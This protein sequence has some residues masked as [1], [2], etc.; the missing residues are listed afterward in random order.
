MEGCVFVFAGDEKE[1]ETLAYWVVRERATRA[2]LSTVFLRKSTGEWIRRRLVA[3]LRE[4]GLEFADVIVNSDNEPAPTSLIAP[5]SA[6]RAMKSGSRLIIENS[7]V[8]SSKS[9]GI[10]ESAVQSVQEMI[11]KIRR[12]VATAERRVSD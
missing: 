1:G 2:V 10:F 5:W 4:I 9:N 6:P 8:G 12:S 7:L 11:R 3:W